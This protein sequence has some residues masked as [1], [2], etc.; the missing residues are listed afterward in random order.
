MPPSLDKPKEHYNLQGLRV[1]K[2]CTTMLRHR[3]DLPFD[4]EG[5]VTMKELVRRV[6]YTFPRHETT[7][8]KLRNAQLIAYTLKRMANASDKS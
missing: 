6:A 4:H 1:S 5:S 2:A 8:E 7:V 3:E